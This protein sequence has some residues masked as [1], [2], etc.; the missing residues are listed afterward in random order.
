VVIIFS[1]LS[2][3]LNTCYP[4]LRFLKEQGL[5]FWGTLCNVTS[6]VIWN[7]CYYVSS[8]LQRKYAWSKSM[9]SIYSH[10]DTQ[11]IP[12]YKYVLVVRCYVVSLY[13]FTLDLTY[14]IQYFCLYLKLIVIV[15]KVQFYHIFTLECASWP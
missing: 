7:L 15:F 1:L 13:A 11:V 5:C 4:V 12:R 14:G 9:L 3:Y 8:I 6:Y 10:I 2:L